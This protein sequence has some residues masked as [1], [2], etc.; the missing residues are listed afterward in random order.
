MKIENQDLQME[1]YLK[2]REQ[3]PGL[4]FE[5]CKLC[6]STP[7]TFTK[8]RIESGELPVIRLRYFG[9]FLVYPKRAAA[10]LERMKIKFKEIK[11]DPKTFFTKKLMLEKFLKNES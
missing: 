2:V 9:T 4:S 5:E 6:C 10:V 11:L 8:E 1:Y 7:F 3:Y